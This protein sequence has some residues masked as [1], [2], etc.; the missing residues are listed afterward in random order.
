VYAFAGADTASTVFDTQNGGTNLSTPFQT[1]SVTYAAGDVV[2]AGFGNN[3]N[4]TTAA[5][6]SSFTGVLKVG[7]GVD[8]GVAAAY[9]ITGAANSVNP[10]WTTTG[11]TGNNAVIACFKAGPA[12]TGANSPIITLS[13]TYWNSGSSAVDSWT[14]QDQIAQVDQGN[15][16]LL[17]AHTG[18]TGFAA[19]EVPALLIGGTDAGLVRTAAHTL[20]ISSGQSGT[21][22]GNLVVGNLQGLNT[23]AITLPNPSGYTTPAITPNGA[24]TSGLTLS[25]NGIVGIVVAGVST[26]TINYSQNGGVNTVAAAVIGW[27]SGTSAAANPDSGISRLGAASLAIGNGT[28]G[29]TS[30]QITATTHTVAASGAAPTSAGTAG[31]VGQ[32]IANGGKLYFCSVTGAAGS[33]TWNTITLVPIL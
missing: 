5:I 16:T 4:V 12:V 1:G 26:L 32:I 18:S 31:T 23:P 30:G 7:N 3:S 14:I 25:T 28:A 22:T 10:T 15:S 29:N 6:N 24:A 20:G 13:G 17:F 33:A 27:T 19:V 2:I 9:L 11:A 8:E 21:A